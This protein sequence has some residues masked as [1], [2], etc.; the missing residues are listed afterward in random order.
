[1]AAPGYALGLFLGTRMFRLASEL[2]FRR[3][4]YLLIAAAAVISL[5]ALDGALR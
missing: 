1:A 4:C 5:P 3:A 2:A